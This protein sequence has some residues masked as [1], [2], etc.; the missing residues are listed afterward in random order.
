MYV[1]LETD[2]QEQRREERKSG[3][4]VILVLIGLLFLLSVG[5]GIYE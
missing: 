2:E 1:E 3:A 5:S 4:I